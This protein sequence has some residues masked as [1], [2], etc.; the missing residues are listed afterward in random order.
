M[1]L[2]HK[3]GGHFDYKRVYEFREV[4]TCDLNETLIHEKPVDPRLWSFRR[5]NKCFPKWI[6]ICIRRKWRNTTK[7]RFVWTNNGFLKKT[8]DFGNVSCQKFSQIKKWTQTSKWKFQSRSPGSPLG[9][10]TKRGKTWIFGRRCLGWA[11]QK[12]ARRYVARNKL[13]ILINC[14]T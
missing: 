2:K 9:A 8:Y 10:A 7:Y 5:R 4:V 6:F 3:S 13:L 14:C 11:R 1:A 12:A